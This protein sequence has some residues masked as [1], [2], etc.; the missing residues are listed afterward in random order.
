MAGR[1]SSTKATRERF[2][3]VFAHPDDESFCCG[4]TIALARARRVRVSLISATKGGRGRSGD[5][6]LWKEIGL[7]KLREREFHR[8]GRTLGVNNVEC[9][10]YEDGS[11]GSVGPRTIVRRIL[12]QLRKL[13]PTLTITFGPD[14][15]SGHSDHQAISRFTTV[16]FR[17]WLQEDRLDAELLSILLPK[18]H[19]RY[20]QLPLPGKLR[21]PEF[22]VDI[23]AVLK[24]KFS[25]MSHHQSQRIA[26]ERFATVHR[27]VP[28]AL[29]REYYCHVAGQRLAP[30]WLF[31]SF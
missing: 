19:Y 15:F 8:A 26:R 3:F 21:T 20:Y 28:E 2:L 7:A 22:A 9:W 14:G 17:Q 5:L 16:A 4:G 24:K 1:S 23:H 10:G 30:R 12:G 13:Q 31:R 25:A 6:K 18:A 27:E 11:L 29:H